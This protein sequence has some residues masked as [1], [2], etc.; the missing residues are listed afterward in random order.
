MAFGRD[1]FLREV[2]GVTA[3]QFGG[4]FLIQLYLL[5]EFGFRA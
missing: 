4:A 3:L 1:S 5:K 2:L